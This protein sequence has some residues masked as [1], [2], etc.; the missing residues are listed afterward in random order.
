MDRIQ[1]IA[2]DIT[3]AFEGSG[4]ATLQTRDKGILSYGRFQFTLVSGSLYT[5]LDK[6]NRLKPEHPVSLTK[7]RRVQS[8]DSTLALDKTFLDTLV[9]YAKD[10]IMQAV[11]DEVAINEYFNKALAFSVTPRGLKTPL[12][13]ALTFDMSINHGLY[14]DIFNMVEDELDVPFKP[15]LADHG[16]DEWEYIVRVALRRLAKMK[17]I[18]KRDNQPG[19]IPRG[20]F[21]VKMA[22]HGDWNLEGKNGV[23]TLRPGRAVPVTPLE[24]LAH[25]G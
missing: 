9:G 12:A 3:A 25:A 7:L 1:K 23:L 10:P 24:E 5:V 19:L 15:K 16:I 6:Y 18:A 17:S 21:W 20:Q 8:K 4:Y 11:Q 22:V 13:I 2:L 14:H